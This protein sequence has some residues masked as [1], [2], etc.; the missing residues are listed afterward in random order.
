MNSLV[1]RITKSF[2]NRFSVPVPILGRWGHEEDF[3]KKK[4]KVDLANEDH[5]FCHEYIK[6]K[7]E[8][9]NNKKKQ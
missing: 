9:L 1:S 5:C 8:E 3:N 2:K 7:S 4:T 6:T